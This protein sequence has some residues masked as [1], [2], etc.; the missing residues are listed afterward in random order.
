MR[1]K[2]ALNKEVDLSAMVKSGNQEQAYEALQL[3]RS[4]ALRYKS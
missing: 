2:A 4:R 1:K 3:Y